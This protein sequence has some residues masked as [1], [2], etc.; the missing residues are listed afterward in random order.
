MV[1]PSNTFVFA[2]HPFWKS[3]CFDKDIPAIAAAY[4]APFL[5]SVIAF[6][7]QMKA[8]EADENP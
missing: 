4:N 6:N 1:N 5:D 3:H 7:E 8:Q 2:D